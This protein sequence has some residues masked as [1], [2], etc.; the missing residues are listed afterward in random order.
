MSGKWINFVEEEPLD[1]QKTKRF[2]VCNKKSLFPIG[3]VKWYGPWRQYC[4]F[5]NANTVYEQQCLLDI[6]K[7]IHHLML[8]RKMKKALIEK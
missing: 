8:E 3:T 7:F 6:T 1:K 2:T 5:P 4:F